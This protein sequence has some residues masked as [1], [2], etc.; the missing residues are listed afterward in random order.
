MYFGWAAEGL[1]LTSEPESDD[2]K[3]NTALGQM[4]LA[5]H[6]AFRPGEPIAW[7]AELGPQSTFYRWRKW[8]LDKRFVLQADGKIS[9][10]LTG[11]KV[12]AA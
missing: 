8:A 5:I 11:V 7:R 12:N 6:A 1:V 10:P 3:D 4:M 9:L 2:P